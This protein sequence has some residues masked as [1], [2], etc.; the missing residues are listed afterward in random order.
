M[1]NDDLKSLVDSICN[2]LLEQIHEHE[3]TT[4]EQ[5]VNYL[6]ESANI[7]SSIKH[8]DVTSINNAKLVF[9]DAYKDI[10]KTSLLSYE[11]TNE[12]FEELALMHEQTLNHCIEEQID[13]PT[14]AEKFNEIQGHM[15][16]EIKKA[17]E[18]ITQLTEQVK[19][20]EVKSNIDSLTKVFNRRALTTY[21]DD[22]CSKKTA[23][24]DFHLLIIDIDDFK[25]I[26][27]KH[28]HIAGDKVLIFIANII[29]KTLRDG[30]KIFRY[31]GEEFIIILNRI[32]IKDCLSI[33]QRLLKIVSDNKLIYKSESL[34]VTM[35]AGTTLL[36]DGDTPDSLI[37]RADAAL[38]KA[39]KNG[40]NQIFSENV[41]GI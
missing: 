31:G 23:P 37:A 14:I 40:K 5:I 3:D 18:I 1:Q 16:D 38:Y 28:G 2:N 15:L 41:N 29:R 22:I 39:K 35:S 36:V 25:K 17:N 13:L 20:L 6:R 11:N 27:D 32:N 9:S 12:K 26:N 10:A 4:K 7:V 30:D 34:N 33:T 21:L 24:K 8:S 19:T